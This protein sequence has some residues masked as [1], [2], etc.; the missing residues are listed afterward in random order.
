MT[1]TVYSREVIERII[2]E[3]SFPANTVVISFYDPAIKRID[4]D[5]THVDYSGVCK[6]VFYSE[7]EDL[8]LEVL[9]RKGYTYDIYF[10]E[11]DDMAMFIVKAYNSGKDIICQCEYG[12]SRSAGCAAAILE[13]FYHTG[14]SIFSNY[15]YYPNQVVYH[16]VYDAIERQRRYYDNKYYFAADADVIKK[17]IEKLKLPDTLLDG[18]Q[19]ENSHSVVDFK[20]EIERHLSKQ[21]MLYHTQEEILNAVKKSKQPIYASFSVSKLRYLYFAWNPDGVGT[22]FRYGYEEITVYIYFNKYYFNNTD[23]KLPVHRRRAESNNAFI[24]GSRGHF[25]SLSFFGKLSWD[26]E[27]KMIDAVPFIITNLK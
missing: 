6:N 9:K 2:A 19:P 14:I 4:K 25:N 7:L 21:N 5:Y 15:N 20:I 10:P 16:K 1:V 8:D 18:Y 3:G 26:S 23:H 12:Q 27:R 24:L 17:N 22:R 11:A 13:Y